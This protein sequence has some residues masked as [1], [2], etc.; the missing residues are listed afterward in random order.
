VRAAAGR[1]ICR[2]TWPEPQ[3]GQAT[4]ASSD[5]RRIR[6]SKASSQAG[7]AYSKMGTPVGATPGRKGSAAPAGV[8]FTPGMVTAT[9]AALLLATPLAA[10]PAASIGPVAHLS[11]GTGSCDRASV[12]GTDI[13]SSNPCYLVIGAAAGLRY[14]LL[15]AG[16]VYEGRQPVDLLTLFQFR[17]P[18]ATVLG[19]SIGL[20]T[21]TG[22]LWRLSVA[23]ELGWRRYTNFAGHGPDQWVGTADLAYAGLVGRAATGLDNPGRR[24]DRIEVTLAW[25]QDLGTATVLADGQLWEVGGWSITMGVGLVADW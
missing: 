15:E 24:T 22:E 1:D 8:E 3:V 20:T 21:R 25:R 11:I 6:V 17:P 10:S 14:R 19:G 9:L 2:F 18:T 4:S 5:L 16:L 7:Q 12:P 23:G 13:R